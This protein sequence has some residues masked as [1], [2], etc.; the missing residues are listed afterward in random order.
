LKYFGSKG[1]IS[2]DGDVFAHLIFSL[3][4]LQSYFTTG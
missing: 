1:A 3:I 4:N 2:N